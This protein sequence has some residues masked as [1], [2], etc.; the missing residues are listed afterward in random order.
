LLIDETEQHVV[1]VAGQPGA[2]VLSRIATVCHVLY[3]IQAR[4]STSCPRVCFPGKACSSQELQRRGHTLSYQEVVEG[5]DILAGCRIEIISTDGT[6]DYKTAILVDLLR[7][8]R[9]RYKVDPKARWMAH[10]SRELTP[11]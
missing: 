4:R 7:V 8:S 11:G 2:W 9:N 6:G 10:F 1:G 5:L 3:P